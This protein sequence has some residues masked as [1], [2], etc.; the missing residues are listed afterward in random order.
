MQ[1]TYR[2]SGVCS[3]GITFE[4]EDGKVHNVRR[5]HAGR[6]AARGGSDPRRGRCKAQRYPLRLQIDVLPRSACQ[7]NRGGSGAG[8]MRKNRDGE[9][10]VFLQN[11]YF[12]GNALDF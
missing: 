2:P 7:S 3:Q 6:G 12:F 5:Q 8:Q 9:I 10:P 4:L 11:P 1:Y